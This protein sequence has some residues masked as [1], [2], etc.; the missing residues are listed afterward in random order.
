MPISAYNTPCPTIAVR[1]VRAVTNLLVHDA[2]RRERPSRVVRLSPD[3]GIHC[4]RRLPLEVEPV[5]LPNV[6]GLTA[7]ATYRMTNTQRS[8][9][10][11]SL[12]SHL[13]SFSQC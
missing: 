11:N 1:I 6:G 3:L 13:P 2:A 10:V 7:A 8:Y 9:A 4:R 12:G 5:I